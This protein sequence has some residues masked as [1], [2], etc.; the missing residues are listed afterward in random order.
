MYTFPLTNL[1]N[2]GNHNALSKHLLEITVSHF[3]P[4]LAILDYFQPKTSQ[5]IISTK[6]SSANLL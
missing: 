6:K 1:Q 5:N 4:F 3:S 2:G